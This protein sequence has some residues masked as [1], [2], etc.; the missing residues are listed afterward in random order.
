MLKYFERPDAYTKS[1]DA[2]YSV[3]EFVSTFAVGD[4]FW[5]VGSLCGQPTSVDGPYRVAQFGPFPDHQDLDPA[6]IPWGPWVALVR[7]GGS[8]E[9]ISSVRDLTNIYHGVMRDKESAERQ[10]ALMEEAWSTE[11]ELVDY[12]NEQEMLADYEDSFF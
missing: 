12:H 9:I 1:G 7:D 4:L 2:I 5:T 6:G 8:R 11:L 10:L 3:E